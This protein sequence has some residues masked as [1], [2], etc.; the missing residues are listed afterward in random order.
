MARGDWLAG[1]EYLTVR[2]RTLR[3]PP[4][5]ITGFASCGSGAAIQPAAS[6]ATAP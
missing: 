3:P 4:I 6:L 2:K 1:Q 5:L